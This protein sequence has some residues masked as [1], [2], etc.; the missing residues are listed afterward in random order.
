MAYNDLGSRKLSTGSPN[1]NA[2]TQSMSM[3]K[4]P[5]DSQSSTPAITNFTSPLSM[6]NAGKKGS[7]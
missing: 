4:E 7:A 6:K 3:K 1:K 5:I 2:R